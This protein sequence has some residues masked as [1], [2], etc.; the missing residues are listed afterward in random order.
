MIRKASKRHKQR[1][2]SATPHKKL[3]S[4][5]TSL[6]KKTRKPSIRLA[7]ISDS[8]QDA[9]LALTRLAKKLES[10]QIPF[11][12][13]SEQDYG[14]SASTEVKNEIA[15]S[16]LSEDNINFVIAVS[17]SGNSF[18][19]EANKHSSPYSAASARLPSHALDALNDPENIRLI[20]ISSQ[21]DSELMF[22]ISKEI[23]DYHERGKDDPRKKA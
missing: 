12:I 5:I 10:A 8:A 16:F 11:I 17:F 21:L 13:L 7:L 9:G 2:T 6:H 1:K 15:M 18:Q 22:L 3:F 4:K 14:F 23:L 19:I 20:D